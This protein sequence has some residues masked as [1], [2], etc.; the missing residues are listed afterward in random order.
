M[1]A[2]GAPVAPRVAVILPAYRSEE[3]VEACL[4]ALAAQTFRD[5]ETVLV[6]SD[7]AGRSAAVAEARHAWVRVLRHPQRLLPHAARNLGVAHTRGELL[8]FSDPDIYTHPDWLACLVRTYAGGGRVVVG[9]LDCFGR[10]WLERGMHLCKFAK[11][12]PGGAPRPVDMSPTGNMLVARADFERAGGLPGELLLGDVELSR[13]LRA[14]GLHL[15]FQPAAVGRHH[16]TYGLRAFLRERYDRG[17]L[18]GEL[19]AGWWQRRPLRLGLAL[20]W[21][22]LPFRL[23]RILGIVGVQ[24]ARA[25]WLGWLALT[26]P[27][28]AAGHA[29]ALLGE[30]RGYLRALSRR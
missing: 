15:D 23:L 1:S 13:R 8:V 22:L 27:L 19:R 7:P 17:V 12:L 16:H 30:A 20:A 25:G 4:D 6:D 9:A 21:T 24:A 3:T 29:A 14:L 18:F 5:F 11:W 26:W 2:A 28:V 10:G